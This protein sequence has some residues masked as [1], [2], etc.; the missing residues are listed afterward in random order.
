MDD[1]IVNQLDYIDPDINMFNDDYLG[2]CKYYSLDT[3]SNLNSFNS[4]FKFKLINFN[5][6]SFSANFNQFEAFLSVTNCFHDFVVL[7][8]TWNTA[9]TVDLSNIE[10]YAGFHTFRNESRGGGISVYVKDSYTAYKLENLSVCTSTIESCIVK[11]QIGEVELVICGIY[12]PHSDSID[13]FTRSLELLISG[14][15]ENAMVVIAGD[16]NVNLAESSPCILN[17][18]SMLNSLLFLPAISLPTRFPPD[19][20]GNIAPSTLDHIF[21]N[22]FQTFLSG[23]VGSSMTDH[24]PVFIF[25]NIKPIFLT[26]LKKIQ[27]RP[28][29]EQKV[30]FIK[31]S[32]ICIRLGYIDR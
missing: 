2:S 25:F 29:S 26:T 3:Y 31:N 20:A 12:R 18:V 8:E 32:I 23:V 4:E 15:G 17:Y 1:G 22:K 21:V 11:V 5:I 7:S 16:M 9:S 28:F 30:K 10:G 13:S 27:F 24:A 6:R 14:L 19:N